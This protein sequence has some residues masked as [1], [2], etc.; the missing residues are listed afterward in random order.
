MTGTPE[1]FDLTI[2]GGGPVGLYAAYYA[3]L[4]QMKTKIIDS[5]DQ[6]GGQLATLYPE[7]YIFD[8]AGFP[9]VVAR[10]LSKT[11]WNR[12][13]NTTPL[14]ICL[15]PSKPSNAMKPWIAMSLAQNV[16]NITPERC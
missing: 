6:L 10:D 16:P 7:K 1:I 3:G 8:V 13:C 5:L 12:V 15:K 4:R 11:S 9:R 14:C 2:I